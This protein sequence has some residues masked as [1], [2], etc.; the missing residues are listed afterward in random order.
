MIF[1]LKVCMFNPQKTCLL[2]L[3]LHIKSLENIHPSISYFIIMGSQKDTDAADRVILYFLS[4]KYEMTIGHKSFLIK[5]R[6]CRVGFLNRRV[7]FLQVFLWNASHI[8]FSCAR[9]PH[10][11]FAHPRSLY[12]NS[13][14]RSC[15]YISVRL[16]N[17]GHLGDVNGQWLS[18]H[19]NQFVFPGHFQPPFFFGNDQLVDSMMQQRVAPVSIMT[20]SPRSHIM[21]SNR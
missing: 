11:L 6:S 5:K 4:I 10:S 8:N 16:G 12:L 1:V 2:Y 14:H 17:A 3:L 19:F 20:H 9:N 18:N 7:T 13:T 21:H 15:P